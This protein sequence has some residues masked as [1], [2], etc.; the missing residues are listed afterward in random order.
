MSITL[1]DEILILKQVRDNYQEEIE[2]LKNKIEN[3]KKE[4]N[5]KVEKEKE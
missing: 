3:E 1:S 2:N 4:K 5:L